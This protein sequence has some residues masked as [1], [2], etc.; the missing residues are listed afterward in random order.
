LDDYVLL[1]AGKGDMDELRRLYRHP[2]SR[3]L[4][5]VDEISHYIN[6]ADTV[7]VPL[8]SGGGTRLKI[9]ESI[10][11]G[12]P[13]VSTSIGAE[14]IDRSACGDLLVIAD[15]WDA[16]AAAVAN[17]P[18]RQAVPPAGFIETYGWSNVVKRLPF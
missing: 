18:P 14:G 3:L 12:V 7:L 15:T 9:V 13:V 16:F 5:S 4:G 8:L 1:I 11:C 2:R 6:A 10:A 17:P